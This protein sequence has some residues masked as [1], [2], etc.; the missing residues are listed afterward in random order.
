[1]TTTVEAVYEAGSLRLVT[2]LELPEGAHVQV[3][4]TSGED[5]SN[6][7]LDNR[8]KISLEVLLAIASMPMENPDDGF[9]GAD[10]DRILYGENGAR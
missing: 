4:V 3:T 6:L 8:A 5:V 10:H 9:S 1:M 7:P 2:P